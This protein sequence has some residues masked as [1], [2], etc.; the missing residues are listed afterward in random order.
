MAPVCKNSDARNSDMLKRSCK[1][2]IG[3]N[4]TKPKTKQQQQKTTSKSPTF[5]KFLNNTFKSLFQNTFKFYLPDKVQDSRI[6]TQ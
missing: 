2:C 1:V 4:K 5:L 6:C 3:K